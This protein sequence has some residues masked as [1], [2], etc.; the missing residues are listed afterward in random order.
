[1][2]DDIRFKETLVAGLESAK[3]VERLFGIDLSKLAD[4][5]EKSKEDNYGYTGD[6]GYNNSAMHIIVVVDEYGPHIIGAMRDRR[7]VIDLMRDEISRI[8]KNA[9]EDIEIPE[10]D[11]T[12]VP[13]RYSSSEPIAFRDKTT[14][15]RYYVISVRM[16]DVSV[17]SESRCVV[18]SKN[19]SPVSVRMY[20]YYCSA[21]KDV[22][23]QYTEAKKNGSIDD[24]ESHVVR[25]PVSRSVVEFTTKDG[26]NYKIVQGQRS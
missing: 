7:R 2:S 5:P 14:G 17:P 9:V 1:M 10:N 18:V 4:T 13:A 15:A 6:E 20:K 22:E 21:D 11:L 24:D 16:L 8:G 26:M 19:G 12:G 25:D 3:I 23:L